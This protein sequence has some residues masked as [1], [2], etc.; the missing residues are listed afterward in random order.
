MAL[1]ELAASE[2]AA[3]GGS[4]GA[5]SPLSDARWPTERLTPLLRAVSTDHLRKWHDLLASEPHV[6]GSPGDERQVE[7][8]A[9]AF[10]EMGLEVEKHE[11]WVYLSR[12]VAAVLELIEDA[13]ARRARTEPPGPQTRGLV[14]KETMLPEDID[15][16]NPDLAWG[17]NA[18]SGSGD[19][20]GEI[21]YANQGTRADF[22]RLRE[23]GVDVRGK[24]VLCRYGGN[25]RGYKVKYAEEAGAIGVVIFTDGGDGRVPTYPVGGAPNDSCIERGSINTLDYPGDPLTPGF[26]STKDARRLDAGNI[27]LPRIPVQPIGWGAA[28]EILIAMASA[29]EQARPAGGEPGVAAGGRSP[30]TP[31]PLPENWSSRI[32]VPHQ[33]IGGT[34]VRLR[35]NVKQERELVRTWNV[36]GTLRGAVSP[37]ECLLV[38][39]HHDAWGFG[40]CD[41]AAGTICTMEAARVF[42]EAARA[43][44]PP[45]RTIKF[46]TWGAEEFGIIGSTEWVESRRDELTSRALAYINLDM[47][48]MGPNFGASASPGLKSVISTVARHVPA[49]GT[50]LDDKGALSGASVLDTWLAREPDPA[51]SGHP[52]F[53]DLGGGSDHVAFWCHAGVASASMGSSGSPGS[54]YHSVYDTLRWYRQNVGD[55]YQPARMVTQVVVGTLARL[56][57]EGAWLLDPG[58]SLHDAA[59]RIAKLSEQNA[60]VL[61]DARQA[62]M[63][64]LETAAQRMAARAT[65]SWNRHRSAEISND[66]VA[67]RSPTGSLEELL[68]PRPWREASG[69]PGRPWFRNALAAPDATSGYASWVLPELS[70]AIEMRD[71][72]A[73]DAAIGALRSRL[74]AIA[75]L[76]DRVENTAP[77]PSDKSPELD[78]P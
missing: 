54:A 8:I 16:S 33:V 77:S 56:D 59:V 47:S 32:P 1:A 9:T 46:C 72:P 2:P 64:E 76:I 10:T 40:A 67:S 53:G 55:N 44:R 41:P 27:G 5:Y 20:T 13:P 45:A 38:G 42:T 37:A 75:A 74:D 34:G 60:A 24:I 68:G 12:P 70:G 11:I 50:E 22:A 7:R 61:G 65:V 51:L 30:A 21:V 39:S 28:R 43:G 3:T 17:W 6:A 63:R 78:R 52:R 62:A 69:L 48:A 49:V 57:D 18:Y 26:E 15:S 36:I 23:L 25:F 19:V 14:I 4:L 66:Q 29:N 71:A 58:R 73:I 35:L 31:P